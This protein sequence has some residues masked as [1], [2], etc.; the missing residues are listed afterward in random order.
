MISAA[1]ALVA[2]AFTDHIGLYLCSFPQ[3]DVVLTELSP[4]LTPS[5]ATF[6]SFVQP[7]LGLS[8]PLAYSCGMEESSICLVN[9]EPTIVLRST[10][11]VITLPMSMGAV[12]NISN[13]EPRRLLVTCGRTVLSIGLRRNYSAENETKTT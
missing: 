3:D 13:L 9:V 8:L 11:P 12:S 5:P 10:V 1:T 6:L 2:A 7:A 4:I